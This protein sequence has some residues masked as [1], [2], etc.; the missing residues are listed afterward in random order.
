M[1]CAIVSR[2]LDLRAYYGEA[3]DKVADR[4]QS[5][6]HPV[7]P[8][9]ADVELALA[10]HPPADAFDHYPNLRAVCTIGAGADNVLACPSLRPD[11]HVVR[12]VDPAQARMMAGFVLWHVIWHQRRFAA[13]LANQKAQVWK[14]LKQRQAQDVPV[15]LL[16]YGEIGSQVAAALAALGFPVLAWSRTPK[17]VPHPLRSF[18]GRD[19]LFAMLAETEVLV[20]L[21]PLTPATVGILNRDVFKAMRRGG[22]L[23]QVGRGPHLVEID[24]LSALESGQLSGASLDVF[25]TEPLTPG[26]PLWSHPQVVVTPH[27]ACDVSIDAVADTLIATAEAISTGRRPPAAVDRIHGY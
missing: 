17:A 27:D 23:I 9:G 26:H 1:R 16:G 13:Y 25:A 5:V 12:V 18:H 4:I 8:S 21:L 11:I 20:N 3:L 19:G 10:W 2:S 24:L 14:R 15:G 7:A 6:M 22:Y